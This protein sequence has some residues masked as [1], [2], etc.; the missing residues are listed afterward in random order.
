MCGVQRGFRM[1]LGTFL[2]V[3]VVLGGVLLGCGA[4]LAWRIRTHGVV[5]APRHSVDTVP[6]EHW[7]Q[8][9]ARWGSRPLGQWGET[10]RSAG[11]LVTVLAM[12]LRHAGV[13]VDPGRLQARLDE[14]DAFTRG[15]AI[16]W[17]RFHRAFP[18]VRVQWRP[19]FSSSVVAWDLARGRLPMVQIRRGLLQRPHWLLVVGADED[20]FLVEDPGRRDGPVPLRARVHAYRVLR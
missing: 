19:V 8:S 2:V 14:E 4:L 10:M 17:A 7:A 6:V 1:R 18:G 15:G 20:A 12:N 16:I 13:D 5:L 9:D 3:T 11:C